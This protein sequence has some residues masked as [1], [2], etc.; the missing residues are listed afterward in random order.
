LY[1]EGTKIPVEIV[2]FIEKL[3]YQQRK[4]LINKIKQTI[5]NL[6]HLKTKK[7]FVFLEELKDEKNK[8]VTKNN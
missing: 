4:K 2:D 1:I 6:E 5:A 8:K 3:L 7:L